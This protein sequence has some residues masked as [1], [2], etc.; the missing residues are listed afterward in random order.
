M[1]KSVPFKMLQTKFKKFRSHFVRLSALYVI[2]YLMSF[3]ANIKS[4]Q[5]HKFLGT[6]NYHIIIIIIKCLFWK[7][8]DPRLIYL[9]GR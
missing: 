1:T 6:H 7:I 2:T 8:P 5:I 3:L 9:D 4:T